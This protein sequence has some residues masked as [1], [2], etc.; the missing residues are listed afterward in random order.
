MKTF[1]GIIS[2]WGS[3]LAA[4]ILAVNIP[5]SG[6]AYVLFLASNIASAY[7]VRGTNTPPV[8]KYQILA[9]I[10]INV[11]GIVRWLI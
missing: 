4:L 7:L 11:V 9:F 1:I 10:V 5:I 2:F 3:V 6:W 8:I